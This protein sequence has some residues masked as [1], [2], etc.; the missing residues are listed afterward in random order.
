M[1]VVGV[2]ESAVVVDVVVETSMTAIGAVVVAVVATVFVGNWRHCMCYR[3]R[4]RDAKSWSWR[5]K[6]LGIS[7]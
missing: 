3:R 2:G 5:N 6:F 1:A 4:R 7:A